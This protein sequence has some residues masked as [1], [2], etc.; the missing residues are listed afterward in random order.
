MS[1]SAMKV[2][3]NAGLGGQNV[4]DDGTISCVICDAHVHHIEKHLGDAQHEEK[5]NVVT[6]DDYRG[7]WPDALVTSPAF[8]RRQAEFLEKQRVEREQVRVQMEAQAKILPFIATYWL[9]VPS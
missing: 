8:D 5:G 3:M 2:Q 7:M 4:N 9:A 6:F 1:A